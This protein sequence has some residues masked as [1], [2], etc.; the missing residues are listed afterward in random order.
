MSTIREME[1]FE[2]ELFIRRNRRLLRVIK[3]AIGLGLTKA[4]GMTEVANNFSDRRGPRAY[5]RIEPDESGK[6]RL[7][8]F[9]RQ[10]NVIKRANIYGDEVIKDI[11]VTPAV[12]AAQD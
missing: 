12:A 10:F 2:L 5:F 1:K 4:E 3:T 6:M 7:S 9:F 8:V 11:E